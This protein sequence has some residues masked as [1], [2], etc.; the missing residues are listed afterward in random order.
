MT[1]P[2]PDPADEG[3]RTLDEFAALSGAFDPRQALRVVPDATAEPERLVTLAARLAR[4]CDTRQTDGRKAWLMRGP[5]RRWALDR[6]STT[7][8]LADRVAWR[9]SLGE[10]DDDT[11]DL[12]DA[13][14]G[15][16]A[17]SPDAVRASLA[18][19]SR[20]ELS[21]TAVALERAGSL[22][23]ASDVLEAV[24]SALARADAEE[25]SAGADAGAQGREEE[26]A[27]L[28]QWLSTPCTAPPVRALYVGGAPGL[29]K[30]A[31]LDAAERVAR[32]S[33]RQWIVTRLDFERRGLDVQDQTG[34]TLELAR[35]V[36][37]ALTT[38]AQA[39]RA[40]RLDA[41]GSP[42]SVG[43]QRSNGEGPDRLPLAL[44][45]ATVGQV[46]S[47]GRPVVVVLDSLEVVRARGE[48]HPE[49]L[50]RWLD[51]LVGLGLQ[52]LAVLAAGRGDA[53]DSA[54][55]RVAGRIDL[56]GLDEAT[57]G[58]VLTALDVP[59]GPARVLRG[60]AA[61]D[62][63][64]LRLAPA[65]L[66][67][68]EDEPSADASTALTTGGPR[69]ATSLPRITTEALQGASLYLVVRRVDAAVIGE[70]LGPHLGA[71]AVDP[72]SAALRFDELARETWLVEPD[73]VAPGFLRYRD[74]VRR[75]LL[76][77]VHDRRP[78]EAA[79]VHRAAAAWYSGRPEPWADVEAAY[80]R[81][82]GMR[83]TPRPPSI[84]TSVLRRF[85]PDTIAELPARAQDV[86]RRAL[87][88]RSSLPRTALSPG[89]APARAAATELAAAVERGDWPE[90]AHLHDR[91]LR[92]RP[93]A[94]RSPE[95]DAVL[96][97]LWR[98]GQWAQARHLLARRD[99]PRRDDGDLATLPPHLAAP[100]L[101]MRAELDP[102]GFARALQDDARLAGLV[103]DLAYSGLPSELSD[104]ALGFVARRA[105]LELRARS[106]GDV[107]AVG[108]AFDTWLSG[109]PGTEAPALARAQQR[110][111]RRLGGSDA[112]P[113][114]AAA[115]AR[116]LSVLSPYV[117][118]VLTLG[119]VRGDRA[120]EQHAAAVDAQLA[121]L[122][123][124]L[125]AGRRP[126]T[127]V[128]QPLDAVDGLTAL[129]L[130][131]EWLGA[132][133]FVLRDAD[134]GLLAWSAERWRRTAAGQW[135]Y[136]PPDADLRLWTRSLDV[137]VAD[138][139]SAL[140]GAA[141]PPGAGREQLTAWWGDDRTTGPRLEVRISRRLPGAL[142]LAREAVPGGV[143][144]VAGVL[145]DRRVPAAFVPPLA[146]LLVHREL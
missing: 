114:D 142:R 90:A 109:G 97:H 98:S 34:L 20:A 49:R 17:F 131:A 111:T 105:G 86:V 16:R 36:A 60:L 130:L 93:F 63:A 61:G 113:L 50:F 6:L 32:A 108:A 41:A 44:A 133:A 118:A 122:G 87:G 83:R 56:G 75:V 18:V 29:G 35:Q 67:L 9:R 77:R 28:E 3:G 78:D 13:L 38:E 71:G 69:T 145:L 88:E 37:G 80:H 58:R 1:G 127:V 2:A 62:P 103:T 124:L 11:G 21:R 68:T 47:T 72:A 119:Q 65:V 25:R 95:G 96:A 40:A 140:T 89:R 52:P 85:D 91:Y 23:P 26:L 64:V 110:L 19:A 132:A 66:H 70:V 55:D 73:P 24:R 123:A 106:W 76:R 31:L 135:S 53:L 139:L 101:E 107:D 134:L 120:L 100:R 33:P 116:L 143:A 81:L 14:L 59:T 7:G 57:A 39:L 48:T 82:Q 4:V 42:P 146:V 79:A 15:E 8:R 45:E 51:A 144:A 74:D 5:E 138:R 84:P 117:D 10:T 121:R 115:A 12:L 94:V 43:G 27:A 99:R 137:T 54:A 136:D 125:P 128:Q 112:D 22:A 126:A 102:S 46:R 104:G 30:S 129:G 141:D 92:D